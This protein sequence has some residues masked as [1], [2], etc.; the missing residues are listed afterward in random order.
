[1][2]V[3]HVHSPE[4]AGWCTQWWYHLDR[5]AECPSPPSRLLT[6]T[7][8]LFLVLVLV[9][10]LEAVRKCKQ[11]NRDFCWNTSPFPISIAFWPCE[12]PTRA[13]QPVYTSSIR[14][15][16][17]GVASRKKGALVNESKKVEQL[18][19]RRHNC[20]SLHFKSSGHILH[21]LYK[22]ILSPARAV[23]Y[24]DS[25]RKWE[26]EPFLWEDT[27]LNLEKARPVRPEICTCGFTTM[28]TSHL[29]ILYLTTTKCSC[30]Q[31]KIWQLQIS[32]WFFVDRA[33]MKNS[34]KKWWQWQ[35]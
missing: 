15:Y 28:L 34:K 21:K 3:N 2:F 9:L 13:G 14:L 30:L 17:R 26:K 11:C 8:V 6:F 1:M 24:V 7:L 5:T 25:Q 19:W 35:R 16:W 20:I 10:V 27:S 32:H 23:N 4:W 22:V 31:L 33:I 29:R 12:G 18:D